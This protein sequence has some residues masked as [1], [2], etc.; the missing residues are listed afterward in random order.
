MLS[1]IGVSL[2]SLRTT[3][4]Q[5]GH[6]E[7]ADVNPANPGILMFDGQGDYAATSAGVPVLSSDEVLE[8]NQQLQIGAVISGAIE[9]ANGAPIDPIRVVVRGAV[10]LVDS[11]SPTFEFRGLPPGSYSISIQHFADNSTG[12]DIEFG[13]ITV[14]YD[15]DATGLT[16]VLP[17]RSSISGRVV[18]SPEG[19]PVAGATVTIDTFAGSTST[20]TTDANGRYTIWGLYRGPYALKASAPGLQT[21]FWDDTIFSAEAT[22][23]RLVDG[24][25]RTGVDFG[26]PAVGAVMGYVDADLGGIVPL[27]LKGAEVTLLRYSSDTGRYTQAARVLTSEY[28]GFILPAVDPGLYTVRVR[29]LQGLGLSTEYYDDAR[30]LSDATTVE[31][32]AG[33]ETSLREITLD[34]RT[35]RISRLQGSDRFATNVAVANYVFPG[36]NPV[37]PVVYIASG[38]DYPDALA[39]G[40]AAAFQGGLLLLVEPDHIPATIA[41]ELERLGPERIVVVGG[42]GSV[43]SSTYQQLSKYVASSANIVRVGGVNRFDTALKVS[44]YA[45]ESEGVVGAFIASGNNFPDALAAGAAASANR[46]PVVIVDGTAAAVDPAVVDFLNDLGTKELYIAG[47]TGSV[48]TQVE[49]GLKAGVA[50]YL[51]SAPYSERY[52]GASRY[53]TALLINQAWFNDADIAFLTSGE[54]FADAL[55]GGPV[56]GRYA[57]PLYLAPPMCI[58]RDSLLDLLDVGANGIVLLGGEGGLN[59]QVAHLQTC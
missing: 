38:L 49:L 29:D 16:V 11:T 35:L 18:Q 6:Y 51:G 27:P 10:L 14:D 13:P 22:E 36:S 32:V 53:E 30:F 56:A 39:A 26:L 59:A 12:K 43:N 37:V 40:P 19:T 33:G 45:F 28:G 46:L 2:G 9:L 55:S 47:G 8:L 31:V 4:D 1:G 44:R 20:T 7:F 50:D 41:A 34:G 48:D 24:E 25:Q 58:P 52:G 15:T 3:T 42:I 21:R 57:L 23:V 5:D 17:L 54:G